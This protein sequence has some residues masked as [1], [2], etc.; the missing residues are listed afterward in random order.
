MCQQALQQLHGRH[1]RSGQDVRVDAP[2][3]GHVL[4]RGRIGDHPVA[5]QLVGLL[6]VLA[7]TLAVALPGE[8][9][10]AAALGSDETEQ[11]R[12]VDGCRDGVG[13]IGVLLGLLGLGLYVA[14]AAWLIGSLVMLTIWL[15][16]QAQLD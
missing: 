6:A 15:I 2:D 11:E 1:A 16:G 9:A 14:A 12:E 4:T 5:G 3:T 13:A 10:I 8:G 7:A